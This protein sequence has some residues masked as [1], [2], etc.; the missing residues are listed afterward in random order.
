MER[1]KSKLKGLEYLKENM[2]NSFKRYQKALE[3]A[4]IEVRRAIQRA[5]EFL[6]G[7]KIEDTDNKPI[8]VK[9]EKIDEKS[10][11]EVNNS[12]SWSGGFRDPLSPAYLQ[13]NGRIIGNINS[14]IYHVS[15]GQCYKKVS[16]KNAVFFDTEKQAKDAGYRRS[17]R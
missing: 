14:N 16:I 9:T 2:P 4:E 13:A 3:K 5:E 17:K 15:D 8:Q 6:Y 12:G 10:K 7:E 1:N 11:N